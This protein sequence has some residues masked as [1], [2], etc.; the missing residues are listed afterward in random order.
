M[1]SV[2]EGFSILTNVNLNGN[3]WLLATILDCAVLE[4]CSQSVLPR[5]AAAASPGN[6]LD[7]QPIE[8]ETLGWDF[9]TSHRQC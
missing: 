2:T 3:M 4:Q 1:A 6:L 8:S 9:N 5:P 7:V